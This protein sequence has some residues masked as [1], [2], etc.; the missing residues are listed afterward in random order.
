MM[1]TEKVSET[2]VLRSTLILLIAEEVLLGKFV[3][4]VSDLILPHCFHVFIFV[5]DDGT[6]KLLRNAGEFLPDYTAFHPRLQH[7]SMF[8]SYLSRASLSQG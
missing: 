2:F 1:E 7:P 8:L 6:S 5:L 4:K 3:V